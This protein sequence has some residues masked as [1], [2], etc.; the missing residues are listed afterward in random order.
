M[1]KKD[2]RPGTNRTSK[3]ET[4][5][6]FQGHREGRQRWMKLSLSER[7]LR[8]YLFELYIITYFNLQVAS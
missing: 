8:I 4:E 3:I 1:K 2:L 5:S 6:A 7:A